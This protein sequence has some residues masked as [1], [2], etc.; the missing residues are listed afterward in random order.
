M[1]RKNYIDKR[2]WPEYNEKL[3]RRGELYFSIE[4]ADSLAED[5][6]QINESKVGST[7]RKPKSMKTSTYHAE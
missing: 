6:A 1:A 3:V 7:A 2:N 5:P 4:I